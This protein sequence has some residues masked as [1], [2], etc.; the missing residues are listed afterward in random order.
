MMQRCIL[1]KAY[2]ELGREHKII[3]LENLEILYML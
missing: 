2:A 1:G 3:P